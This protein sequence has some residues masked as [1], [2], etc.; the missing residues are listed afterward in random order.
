M[1]RDVLP[2][3]CL[4]GATG[5]GKTAFALE[6][7]RR[8]ECEIVNTDSRQVYRDFPITCAQPTREEQSICPHHLYG[9][10]PT[11]QKISAGEWRAFAVEKI[12]AVLERGH[13]PLLVGGTGMYFHVLLHGI[14]PIPPIAPHIRAAW[15]EKCEQWGLDRLYRE[16]SVIDPHYASTVHPH[17]RQRIVRALEVY[18]ATGKN[19][20][21]WHGETGKGTAKCLGPLYVVQCEMALL[22]PR[23]RRRI[24]V[25]LSMGA[26]Q[27]IER[28]YAIC[29]DTS[30]PG[31]SGIG[32][33]EILSYVQGTVSRE[34][35]VQQWY[36]STRDYAKRQNTWFRGRKEAIWYRMEDLPLLLDSL[37]DEWKKLSQNLS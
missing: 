7:A 20:S 32:C 21:F 3:I 28:A 16:V 14:A 11:T 37:E 2:C 23:L 18:E 17:D 29:P 12:E 34:E 24:E 4:A 33:R 22:E 9:F 5:T 1:T 6:I 35:C 8:F 27:E 26:L 13:M 30:A 10:M 15:E 19:L 36:Q 25:M 31:W